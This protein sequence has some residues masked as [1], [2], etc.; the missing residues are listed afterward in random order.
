VIHIYKF[1]AEMYYFINTRSV[2]N[3]YM[4]FHLQTCMTTFSILPKMNDAR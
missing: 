1:E 4:Y 2:I 3:L